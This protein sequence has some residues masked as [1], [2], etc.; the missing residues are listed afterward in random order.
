MRRKYLFE[1]GIGKWWQKYFDFTITLKLSMHYEVSV[2][3]YSPRAGADDSEAVNNKAGSA[4]F[5]I[6]LGVG[7]LLSLVMFILF[8]AN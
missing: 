5:S 7:L 1:T 8:E 3:I 2:S 4:M 6:L